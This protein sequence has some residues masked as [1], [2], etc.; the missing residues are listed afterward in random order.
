VDDAAGVHIRGGSPFNRVEIVRR[1]QA[2]SPVKWRYERRDILGSSVYVSDAGTLTSVNPCVF[3]VSRLGDGLRTYYG[4]DTADLK[5]LTP[6]TTEPYSTAR[7]FMVGLTAYLEGGAYPTVVTP[8]YDF[9]Y[10]RV[11]QKALY[12]DLPIRAVK[13]DDSLCTTGDGIRR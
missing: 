11:D 9:A 3:R 4:S 13:Y 6:A 8:Y 10:Y 5:E 7:P 12:Y 2:G 1:R